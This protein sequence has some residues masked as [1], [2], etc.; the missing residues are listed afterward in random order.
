[1]HKGQVFG[2][3]TEGMIENKCQRFPMEIKIAWQG[4]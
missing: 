4:V 2:R 3:Y 1:M